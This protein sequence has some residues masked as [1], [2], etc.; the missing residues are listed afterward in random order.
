M[1]LLRRKYSD[2]PDS[3]ESRI[4]LYADPSAR[5]NVVSVDEDQQ[6]RFA[7]KLERA[8]KFLGLGSSLRNSLKRVCANFEPPQ[9]RKADPD[10]RELQDR[11]RAGSYYETDA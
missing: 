3:R 6:G 9:G 8:A 10:A 2:V 11:Q 7:R 1:R 5:W 4:A